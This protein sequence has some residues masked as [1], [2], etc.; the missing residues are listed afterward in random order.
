MTGPSLTRTYEIEELLNRQY[1][2]KALS[3][4]VPRL[5]V[6]GAGPQAGYVASK[7]SDS[8]PSPSKRSLLYYGSQFL[9][10]EIEDMRCK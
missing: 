4:H 2:D 9:I 6:L 7:I 8:C 5:Y 1:L 10:A 3:H